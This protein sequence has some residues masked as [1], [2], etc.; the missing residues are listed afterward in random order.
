MRFLSIFLILGIGLFISSCKTTATAITEDK[1]I[2]IDRKT[3][4]D[5]KEIPIM[6]FD[7][8]YHDFG[9][10]KKGE[11]RETTFHFTNTGT[12]DLE[13]EIVTACHC[14]T[15]DYSTL[16]VPPG[17]KGQISMLF[18]STEKVES[19]ELDITIILKN[20]NPEN[21]YPIVEELKY[22]FELIK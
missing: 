12:V 20:T 21:G 22:S 1:R 10:I 2:N 9:E 5:P 14:T 3:T 4:L 13:I 11:K 16:P 17:G 18:D 19:E 8:V 7:R 15:L 6:T